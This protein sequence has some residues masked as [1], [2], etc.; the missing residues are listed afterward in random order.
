MGRPFERRRRIRH[1]ARWRTGRGAYLN[2]PTRGDVLGQSGPRPGVKLELYHAA[3][4][5]LLGRLSESARPTTRWLPRCKSSRDFAHAHF[6][7]LSGRLRPSP[8]KTFIDSGFANPSA[9]VVLCADRLSL[10]VCGDPNPFR[11][12]SDHP[13]IPSSRSGIRA[14]AFPPRHAIHKAPTG[15]SSRD[16]PEAP[17]GE[18]HAFPAATMSKATYTAGDRS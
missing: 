7:H 16:W 11:V 4:R 9:C 5:I 15:C 6:A 12:H 17:H 13:F 8:R 3:A 14:M 18:E 10:L 2:R 1:R